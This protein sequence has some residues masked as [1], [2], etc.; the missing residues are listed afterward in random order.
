[1]HPVQLVRCG[2][3]DAKHLRCV[4]AR[5]AGGIG[6]WGEAEGTSICGVAE[7]SLRGRANVDGREDRCDELAWG[8][9][10]SK[11]AESRGWACTEGTSMCEVWA[12]MQEGMDMRALSSSCACCCRDECVCVGSS[13]CPQMLVTHEGACVS[14]REEPTAEIEHT[15]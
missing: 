5:T 15:G 7:T 1:M 4:Q 10:M 11:R 3:L 14:L 13:G 9:E 6:T 12:V 2:V 8:L